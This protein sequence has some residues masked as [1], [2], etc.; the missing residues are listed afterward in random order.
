MTLPQ[1]EIYREH[2]ILP[3]FDYKDGQGNYVDK[4]DWHVFAE[5]A[6]SGTMY[7]Y[8]SLSEVKESID[9]LLNQ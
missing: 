9:D 3:Q 8:C 4:S 7:P 6:E 1:P 5:G 2:L